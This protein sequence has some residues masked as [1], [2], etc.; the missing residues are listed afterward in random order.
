MNDFIQETKIVNC[1]V[2]AYETYFKSRLE[3]LFGTSA[4]VEVEL[5]WFAASTNKII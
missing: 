4:V 1:Y 2:N 5:H 3:K